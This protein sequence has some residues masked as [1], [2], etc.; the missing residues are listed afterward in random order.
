MCHQIRG[1]ARSE[2]R[3]DGC[4]VAVAD[5]IRE[6]LQCWRRSDDSRRC[7]VVRGLAN[8]VAVERRLNLLHLHWCA[9]RIQLSI[10]NLLARRAGETRQ[11]AGQR[12]RIC[13]VRE[14]IVLVKKVLIDGFD[15]GEPTGYGGV[16]R[17]V[18]PTLS[19][20]CTRR[21]RGLSC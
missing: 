5:E 16:R 1:V 7:Q 14:G 10:H 9:L 11:T 4:S 17:L 8:W 6:G 15:G 3:V 18:K 13:Q 12:I 21:R 19:P 2:E 20:R